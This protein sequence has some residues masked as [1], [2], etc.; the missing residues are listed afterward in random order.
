MRVCIL[1][2]GGGEERGVR[3]ELPL[4]PASLIDAVIDGSACCRAAA[5]ALLIVIRSSD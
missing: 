3:S 2:G 5:K 4:V 1:A